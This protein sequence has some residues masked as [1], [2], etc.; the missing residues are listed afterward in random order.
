M[1]FKGINVVTVSILKYNMV[2]FSNCDPFNDTT[3]GVSEAIKRFNDVSANV[4]L[5]GSVLDQGDAK[6]P[7]SL[8][9]PCAAEH[10]RRTLDPDEIS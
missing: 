7:T 2:K 5:V 3:K 10:C 9:S 6:T 4:G 8:Q 1:K